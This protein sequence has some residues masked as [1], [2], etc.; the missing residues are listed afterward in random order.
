MSDQPKRILEGADASESLREALRLSAEL[1]ASDYD[2]SKGLAR[3]QAAII[4]P[5]AAGPS[6]PSSSVPDVSAPSQL[7]QVAG[8]SAKWWGLAAV[9]TASVI[10][11]IGLF[12]A[13]SRAPER[14][15]D[16][17]VEPAGEQASA[18]PEAPPEATPEPRL[19]APEGPLSEQQA[20]EDEPLVAPPSVPN[21]Q[22]S[23]RRRP[24]APTSGDVLLRREIAQLAEARRLLSSSPARA[25]ALVRASQREFRAG[26]FGE[27]RAALEVFAL[28]SLGRT[29]EAQR[30]GRSFVR[31]YA[32]GPFSDRVRQVLD[33]ENLSAD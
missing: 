24:P 27:E 14:V 2:S 1:P 19:P 7:A 25:L 17:G 16:Q 28:V 31:R 5:I 11:A 33:E 10:L 6:A 23:A 21:P 26:M 29:P 32:H 8:H 9:G 12:G 4:V 3:L 22:P 20:S 13:D 30:R 15:D 18:T